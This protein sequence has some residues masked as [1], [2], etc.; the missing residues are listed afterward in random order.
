M[1]RNRAPDDSTVTRVG[2]K[3]RVG[4]TTVAAR[5]FRLGPGLIVL[6]VAI[7]A[8]AAEQPA[9]AGTPS[10]AATKQIYL[11]DCA[12]CHGA[13]GEGTVDGPELTDAGSAIV[14]YELSTGRMPLPHR[15]AE[16]VRRA[17]K[18]DPQTIAALVS[19]VDAFGPGGVPIPRLEGA[20][21]DLPAGGADFRR[22]CAACHQAA[23]EGGALRTGEAPSLLHATPLEVAEAVRT[24]PGDMPVFDSKE[25]TDAQV[26]GIAKYVQ[27]LHDPQDPGGESLWH[28]GPLPE[29]M[30]AFVV[31]IA[32]ASALLVVGQRR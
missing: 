9:Q 2:T 32:L 6:S 18:Y 28:L 5:V 19:Y 23:G 3:P 14:D 29:G 10:A 31:A 27:Y 1:R 15:G 4:R 16:V 7:G 13:N 21:A 25:F 8:L 11:R 30:V 22:D 24:G 26:A 17:P 12:S 20:T